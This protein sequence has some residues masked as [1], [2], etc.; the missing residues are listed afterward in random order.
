MGEDSFSK[1]V[2]FVGKNGGELSLLWLWRI[3]PKI[4]HVVMC[5]SFYMYCFSAAVYMGLHSL[6]LCLLI[7]FESFFGEGRL[8]RMGSFQCLL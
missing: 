3:L 7:S 6:E 8:V 5:N 4:F 2:L 1:F